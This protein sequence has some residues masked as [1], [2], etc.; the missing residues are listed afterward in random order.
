MAER[1]IKRS[2][3]VR[4]NADKV[5]LSGIIFSAKCFQLLRVLLYK[6]GIK[7]YQKEIIGQSALSPNTAVPLLDQLTSYGILTENTIAGTRFY[8]IN[9]ENSVLKQLKILVNVSDI[10]EL[11]RDIPGDIELYLFGSAARGEDTADSDIDLLVLANV[12]AAERSKL[13]EQIKERLTGALN[14]E[15]NPVIFTPIEYSNL[16]NKEKAFYESIEKD[17][18]R[19]I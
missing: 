14:R 19:V 3:A 2:K 12:N 4:S 5:K 1:R 6:P 16:Y 17:K 13:R 8:S 9:E 11:A 18:V 7:M 15:V 10:Y